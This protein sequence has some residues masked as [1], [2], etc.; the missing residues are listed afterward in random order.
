LG[1]TQTGGGLGASGMVEQFELDELVGNAIAGDEDALSKLLE[2]FG[3]RLHAR[4]ASRTNERYRSMV[5]P[6]DVLQVTFTEAFLRMNS[7]SPDGP[8]SFEAWLTR[9]ADHNLIDAI[10]GLERK[11]DPPPRKRISPAT[12][13]DSYDSLLAGIDGSFTAPSH[14]AARIEVKP[15][16]DNALDKLP[17][18]YQ[19]VLRLF[20]MEGK[21]AVEVGQVMNKSEAA[22]YMMAGRARKRLAELLGSSS[23]YFSK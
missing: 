12:G 17:A 13:D 19:Q 6:E 8:G 1:Y 18:G 5:S 15:I 7:F 21:T 23:Q 2:Q 3:A 14:G 10:R 9:I 4:V 20:D 22:V 16:I 11:K